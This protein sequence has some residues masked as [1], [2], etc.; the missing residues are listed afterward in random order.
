M[1]I[2]KII[3]LGIG[4]VCLYLVLN[5]KYKLKENFSN[6]IFTIFLIDVYFFAVL[7]VKE[8]SEY[9]LKNSDFVNYLSFFLLV[10]LAFMLVIMIWKFGK[11]LIEENRVTYLIW[12]LSYIVLI[13]SFIYFIIYNYNEKAFMYVKNK[14]WYEIA[15]DFI[16]YSFNRG[17]TFGGGTLEPMSFLAKLCSLIQTVIFYF[18]IGKALVNYKKNKK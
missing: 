9:M 15:F 7:E 13:F 3:L 10:L 18:V 17:L 2:E 11:E 4:A 16:Y 6:I 12:M 1:G 5:K 8:P 14:E